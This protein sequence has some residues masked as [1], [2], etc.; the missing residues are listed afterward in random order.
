MKRFFF[1]LFLCL[2][3]LAGKGLSAQTTIKNSFII[4][5]N[6][7]PDKEEYYKTVLYK[8]EME[9]FRLQDKDEVLTFKEGF[10]VVMLSAKKLKEKGLSID[11]E[12]YKK[13][14]TKEFIMPVFNIGNGDY[15]MAQYNYVTAKKH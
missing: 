15:I 7:L 4:Q 14:F 5:N 8:A 12:N 9:G 3:L 10:E 11:I 1:L 6:K 13:E 2:T